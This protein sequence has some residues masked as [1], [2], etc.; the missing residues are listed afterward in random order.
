MEKMVNLIFKM[1]KKKTE[2][3]YL[4]AAML[5]VMVKLKLNQD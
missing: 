5:L 3:P 4:T 1:S 2:I